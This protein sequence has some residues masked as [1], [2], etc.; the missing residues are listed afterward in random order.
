MMLTIIFGGILAATAYLWE[1]EYPPDKSSSVK[2]LSRFRTTL[3]LIFGFRTY[4]AVN[5][6]AA[7]VVGCMVKPY[8][9][10]VN[11]FATRFRLVSK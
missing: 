7:P 1:Q 8:T 9:A 10:S 6:T 3:A 5:A 2:R 11:R 4:P